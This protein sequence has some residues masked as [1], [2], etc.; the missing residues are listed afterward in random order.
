MAWKWYEITSYKVSVGGQGNYYGGVQLMGDGLYALLTFHKD[1][2]LPN[3]SAPTT[4]GQR[5]YGH[6][7]YQQMQT[8]VDL[9]RNEKPI[10]FGWYDQ[11]PNLFHLMTGEEPVG[12]GDGILAENAS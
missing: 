11:N 10:R 5:F 6:M 8:M 3:A 9:L 1:G 4:F 12:E 7:D 2:P